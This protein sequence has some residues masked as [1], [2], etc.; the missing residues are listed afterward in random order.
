MEE[1]KTQIRYVVTTSFYLYADN[2]VEAVKEMARIEKEQRSNL[3][4]RFSVDEIAE[5]RF[6]KFEKRVVD[7]AKILNEF[8]PTE[9]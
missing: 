7:G 4:N 2:D 5:V 1:T 6:G 8:E 9:L 3:D